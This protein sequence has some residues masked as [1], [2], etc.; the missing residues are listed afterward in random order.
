V[1]LLQLSAE[2]LTCAGVFDGL[3]AYANEPA[4]GKT[5]GKVGHKESGKGEVEFTVEALQVK[6][7][8]GGE[9]SEL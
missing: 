2:M 9:R 7:T 1:N 4:D 3:D 8:A 6:L 5:I